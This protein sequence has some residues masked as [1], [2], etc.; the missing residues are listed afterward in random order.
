MS[1]QLVRS[2]GAGGLVGAKGTIGVV[3]VFQDNIVVLKLTETE[4]V[5]TPSLA[6]LRAMRMVSYVFYWSVWVCAQRGE[7]SFGL[8]QPTLEASRIILRV[9][10]DF[11]VI[12]FPNEKRNCY[13]GSSSMRRFFEIIEVLNLHD[14][15]LIR[16]PYTWC[17]GLNNQYILRLDQC[18]A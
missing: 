11:N 9:K 13:R 2:L 6:M 14:L 10:G 8:N 15:P 4:V 5:P 1:I 12:R 17:G 18:L 3:I 16:G 7:R